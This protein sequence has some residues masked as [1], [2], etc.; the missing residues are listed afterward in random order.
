[1]KTRILQTIKASSL[2]LALALGA[3]GGG[4]DPQTQS[5]CSQSNLSACGGSGAGT[6]SNGSGSGSGGTTS[7]Q[8]SIALSLK[9]AGGASVTSVSPEAPG[10]LQAVVKDSKGSALANVAVSFVTTDKTGA[11]VPSSGTALTDS[12]GVAK[13]G[14]AAGTQAGA[15]TV[16]ASASTNGAAVTGS[17]GYTVAFPALTFSPIAVT[18]A[19][20]SAGGTANLSVTVMS[21]SSAFAPAQSVSFSSPCASAGKATISSPVITVNG[22]AS[23]S[24]TD[25]GCGGADTI[26][27]STSLG[28]ASFSQTGSVTVLAATAGQIAFVS[29]LPQNIAIKGTGGAGRQES[30]NVTF[31]VLDKNGNPVAG[32]LVD[33]AL[34]TSVGG[35]SLNPS[36][37]SSGAD[38]TLV[39]VVAAGIVNT[40]VRVLATIRGSAISSISDQLIVSTGV[41]DQN[42]FT[43]SPSVY[44]IEC[45]N[46]DGTDFTSVSAFVADHFNNPVPDGTGVSFTTEGGAVDAACL[47]GLNQTTLTDG[48]KIL[49]KGTPGQCKTRFIC[50]NPRPADGRITVLGYA[51]GEES[52]TDDP[53]NANGTNR[54]DLG[55]PF[56][57][58][59]D[60]FR[61][62]R[63]I[64]DAD[65]KNANNGVNPAAAPALGEPYID[66]DGNG[67]WNSAGDGFYN[68]V[69]QS[70]PNGKTPTIHVREAFV[71][72]FSTSQ[73]AITPITTFPL[74]LDVCVDGTKFVNT[75][76]AF[77]VAVRDINPTI[78]PGNTLAGNI[79]PAGTT[80]EFKTSNGTV[81]GDSSFTVPN[82]NE[83]NQA[84]WTYTLMLQSDATQGAAPTYLCTNP[85]TTGG[86]TVK[87][88]TPLGVITSSPSFTVKD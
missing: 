40:P 70:S 36:S 61:Y 86:V 31:K 30:A 42:S 69:L 67:F 21:G 8:S 78:F 88:T 75:P 77:Q 22:V 2:L 19:S 12:S 60:P 29:A 25:K 80:I 4:S 68:G 10:T 38:G 11:F 45:M 39:T 72:V 82:T 6:G 51:L 27:A 48:S 43:I 84:V 73:A 81:L 59:R 35:L 14:L 57:D 85:V 44:N 56:T 26:T 33:F 64:A 83:P 41:P 47:T 74:Q 1:M 53:A 16:N 79:L 24:Y 28:G 7:S 63:A 87:V 5:Q 32:A 50:Q 49:Q 37:T 66:S 65:A 58:L 3:C 34:T 52:F 20:L 9:N 71:L 18:P 17:M 13:L 76:K 54:Y 62:D 55:E 23:T 46:H 15:F